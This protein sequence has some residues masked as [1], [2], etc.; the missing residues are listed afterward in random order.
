MKKLNPRVQQELCDLMISSAAASAAMSAGL[1]EQAQ[2]IETSP[3]VLRRYIAALIS[4]DLESL[5]AESDQ[6]EALAR[7]ASVA[8]DV[9]GVA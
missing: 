4:G 1:K 8:A 7:S 6:L 9:H 2:K 3:G 5:L